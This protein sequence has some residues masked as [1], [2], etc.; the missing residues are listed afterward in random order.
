MASR[1]SGASA[2]YVVVYTLALVLGR[3]AVTNS[4]GVVFFWPAAG[5]AA[6]WMLS[7]RSRARVLCDAAL[8]LTVTVVVDVLMGVDVGPALLYAVAN[9]FVGLVVRGSSARLEH[10]SFWGP[11]PRR[12]ASPGDLAG[13]GAA[14]VAAGLASAVP[15][16][17]AMRL[18]SG[19]VSE[20][21]VFGW[22]VRNACST[23][24]V[25]AAVLGLLTMLMRAH[26]KRGWSAILVPEAR[27]HW[28]TELVWVG[29][30][31]TLGAA[32]LFGSDAALPVAYLM[33]VA[34]TWIGY[35]FS[36]AVGGIY[37]LVFSTL[38]VLWTES[39]RGPFGPIDDL[40]TRAIVVQVY[41]LV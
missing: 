10:R 27:E 28:L 23:F 3:L 41:I 39:G 33:M 19:A 12:M 20:D 6:L 13:L 38:A 15:G 21:Q 24:V 29:A 34:S 16:L 35:R 5:V 40:T 8:L 11:L 14:S 18:S 31:T 7:G 22:V 25:V 30:A 2:A 1:R 26:A 17:L 9:L 32:V 37:A 36:P 4:G